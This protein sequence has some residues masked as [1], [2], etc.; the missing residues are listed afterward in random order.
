MYR[1]AV[2]MIISLFLITFAVSSVSAHEELKPAELFKEKCSVC[3]SLEKSL[4]Q[5]N[6]DRQYWNET[7]AR[8]SGRFAIPPTAEEQEVIVEYLLGVTTK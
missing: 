3:H 1:T 2:I 8:M 4:K 6:K 5:V 7:V